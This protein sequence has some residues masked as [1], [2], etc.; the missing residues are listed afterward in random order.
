MGRSPAAIREQCRAFAVHVLA[1]ARRFPAGGPCDPLIRQLT[2]AGTGASANF[3]AACRSRSRA[4]FLSC[5]SLATQEVHAAA[6]CLAAL[7]DRA[8]HE[9]ADV[10][11]SV[12][13]TSEEEGVDIDQLDREARALITVFA[14]MVGGGAS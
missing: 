3:H 10:A 14:D 5:L 9:P 2:R 4:T 6:A 7:H 12:P 1:F 8:P 13:V 11:M